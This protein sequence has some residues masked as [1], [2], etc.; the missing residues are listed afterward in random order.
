MNENEKRLRLINK[1][2]CIIKD[3]DRGCSGWM[4]LYDIVFWYNDDQIEFLNKAYAKEW[5]NE[6]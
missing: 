6:D 3:L 4:H 5:D 1:L 2:K